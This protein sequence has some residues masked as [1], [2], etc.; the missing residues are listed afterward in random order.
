MP[1]PRATRDGNAP[2]P[3][4]HP[5]AKVDVLPQQEVAQIEAGVVVTLCPDKH[6]RACDPI[7]I[8]NAIGTRRIP[9]IVHEER[10]F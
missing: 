2:S 4:L 10:T 7:R 1:S 8:A 6:N 3:F 5:E 9:G